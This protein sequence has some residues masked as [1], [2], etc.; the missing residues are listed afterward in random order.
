MQKKIVIKLDYRLSSKQLDILKNFL[1]IDNNQP[2]FEI[3]LL[4]LNNNKKG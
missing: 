3:V 1:T 4:Q 2:L